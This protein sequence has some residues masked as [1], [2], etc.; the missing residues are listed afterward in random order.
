MEV[1]ARL[2]EQEG[3][4]P[5][6]YWSRLVAALFCKLIVP[7]APLFSSIGA[8]LQTEVHWSSEYSIENEH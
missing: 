5:E 8:E 6:Q 1:G 4:D 7:L 3:K 2:K